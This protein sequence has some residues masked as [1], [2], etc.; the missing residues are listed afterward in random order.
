MNNILIGVK[1]VNYIV[2]NYLDDESLLKLALTNREFYGY[3]YSEQ[4]FEHRILIYYGREVLEYKP[5]DISFKNEYYDIVN[6]LYKTDLEEYDKNYTP[7]LDLIWIANKM[8]GWKPNVLYVIRT[9]GQDLTLFQKICTL[10][11]LDERIYLSRYMDGYQNVCDEILNY[12]IDKYD[13]Y[14]SLDL[15]IPTCYAGNLKKLKY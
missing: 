14:P 6:V 4:Y 2:F 5:P 12:A 10:F 3:C 9:C 1:P 8:T 11:K 15:L 7:R 13:L